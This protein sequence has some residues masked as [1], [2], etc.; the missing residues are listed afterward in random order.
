VD[1]P[2]AELDIAAFLEPI[3][4]VIRANDDGSLSLDAKR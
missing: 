1:G 2:A 4:S 3:F